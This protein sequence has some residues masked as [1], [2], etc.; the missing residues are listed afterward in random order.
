M[1]KVPFSRH[2]AVL[3]LDAY[4]NSVATGQPRAR[5]AKNVSEDLRKMAINNGIEFDKFATG[6]YAG[7]RFNQENGRYQLLCGKD[8]RKDQAYFLYHDNHINTSLLNV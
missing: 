3:L 6:H 4:L 5:A 2:E 7:V 8:P 1:K